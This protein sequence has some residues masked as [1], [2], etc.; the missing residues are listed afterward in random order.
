MLVSGYPKPRLVGLLQSLYGSLEVGESK[1][2]PFTQESFEFDAAAFDNEFGFGTEEKGT[3]FEHPASGG[4]TEGRSYYLSE[5]GHH[6]AIGQRMGR[7]EIVDSL[8]SFTLNELGDAF[9]KVLFVKPRDVLPP[10]PHRSTDSLFGKLTKGFVD[11]AGF[12][13]EDHGGAEK[14]TPGASEVVGAIGVFPG[15]SHF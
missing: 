10:M 4:K 3:K 11:P 15:M 9:A 7:G 5:S 2:I 12:V 8:R 6:F 1:L 13:S 14:N